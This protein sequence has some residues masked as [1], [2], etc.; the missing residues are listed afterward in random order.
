MAHRKGIINIPFINSTDK[1]VIFCKI[2]I[3]LHQ[4]N[5][6]STSC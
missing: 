5:L 6:V 2:K 4:F 1:R 3:C